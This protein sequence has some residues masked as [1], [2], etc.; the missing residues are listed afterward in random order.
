MFKTERNKRLFHIF[1]NIFIA[2]F[3]GWTLF[4]QYR[5]EYQSSLEINFQRF[6][7]LTL[8][9]FIATTLG[10]I[11]YHFIKLRKYTKRKKQAA[12]KLA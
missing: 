12:S 2:F 5:I 10:R 3:W 1:S 6:Y 7:M 4:I 9:I 8:W 11:V